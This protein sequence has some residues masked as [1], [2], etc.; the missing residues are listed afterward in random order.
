MQDH[1]AGADLLWNWLGVVWIMFSGNVMCFKISTSQMLGRNCCAT[2][3][4]PMLV[5]H[6]YISRANC[7]IFS[8]LGMLVQKMG[9]GNVKTRL[10]SLACACPRCAS[11]F[12]NARLAC[13]QTF[14]LLAWR[15]QWKILLKNACLTNTIFSD[16]TKI[17]LT[18]TQTAPIYEPRSINEINALF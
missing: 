11:I 13:A 4:L 3:G 17:R 9:S 2:F 18:N 16:T 7:G 6:R 15:E 12:G 14:S 8:L 1:L 5:I 10:Q